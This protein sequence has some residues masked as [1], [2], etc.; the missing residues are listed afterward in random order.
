MMPGMNAREF[1]VKIN[2]SSIFKNKVERC[3]IIIFSA[4]DISETE[5]Q[6]LLNAGAD[7][8]AKK[9]QWKSLLPKQIE[10]L[11]EYEY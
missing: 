10:F 7:M 8:F 2:N 11:L 5:E 9:G 1:I 6:N 3:P 4:R